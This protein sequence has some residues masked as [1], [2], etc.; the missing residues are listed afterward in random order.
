LP[1][2]LEREGSSLIYMADSFIKKSNSPHSGFY[3]HDIDALLKKIDYL[4]TDHRKVLLLGVSFALL[5]MAEKAQMDLSHC[6]IMETGGMKGRR[7]ELTRNELH[8]TLTRQFNVKS[9]YSEYGMTELLSQGY[10]MGNGIFVAPP[11]LKILI[12]D[13]NDPFSSFF[14]EKTGMVNVVDLANIYS[15]AFIETQDLGRAFQNGNFEVLGRMDN[16]DV[17]GCNLLVG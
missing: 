12:R 16:S 10:S 7:K 11:Y 6:I 9:I 14:K 8:E 5:D 3:L 13:I 2:Y 4:K 15:C 1:S 17:R